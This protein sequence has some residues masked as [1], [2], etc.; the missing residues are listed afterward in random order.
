VA[1]PTKTIKLEVPI[2]VD[3]NMVSEVIA[4]KG[5]PREMAAADTKNGAHKAALAYIAACCDIPYSS[6]LNMDPDDFE[7]VVEAVNELAGPSRAS[8][9]SPDA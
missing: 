8:G 7:R 5:G 1:R 4:R 9:E 2:P 3:G 6:I